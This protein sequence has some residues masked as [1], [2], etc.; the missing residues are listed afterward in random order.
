VS[1]VAGGSVREFTWTPE[2]FGIERR[3]LDGLSI[4]SPAASAAI[5]RRVL[6]GEAG[7]ARD[8]V[9]L[10]AAAGLLAAGHATEPQAAAE[11]AAQAIDSGGAHDLL[12]RLAE[13]S[14][15][16]AAARG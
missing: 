5:I 6:A 9:I 14:H 12:A 11:R 7:A 15:R 4:D 8:I 2:D 1:E 10:N 13:C 3:A 16:S